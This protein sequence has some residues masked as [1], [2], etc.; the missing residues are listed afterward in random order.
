MGF[1]DRLFGQA[2][3]RDEVAIE[4]DIRAGVLQRCEVCRAVSDK[5]RDGRLPSADALAHQLFDRNDPLVAVFQGDRDDLLA[6]LRSVRRSI[7]YAC[8]CES[9]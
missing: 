4:I 2:R 3:R 8:I 9:S 6:R 5:G 7:P 1:F